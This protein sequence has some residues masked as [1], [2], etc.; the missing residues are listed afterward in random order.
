MSKVDVVDVIEGVVF[1]VILLIVIWFALWVLTA[2][3]H[4]IV[5]TRAYDRC[6]ARGY[7]NH[8][9]VVHYPKFWRAETYCYKGGDLQNGVK[10]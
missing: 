4:S 10:L 9:T 2:F 8:D 3:A 7:E 1:T 5:D 6:K